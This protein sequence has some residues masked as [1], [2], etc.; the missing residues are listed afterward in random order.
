MEIEELLDMKK[1]RY[2][3][4]IE[5]M[6]TLSELWTVYLK[7]RGL[8]KDGKKLSGADCCMMNV[9]FKVNREANKHTED[10]ENIIDIIG[11]TKIAQRFWENKTKANEVIK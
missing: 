11:Y 3:D 5:N 8:L 1:E 2:G 4:A 9:L 10:N 7:R 6:D